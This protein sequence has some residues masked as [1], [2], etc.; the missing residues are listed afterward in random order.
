[1]CSTCSDTCA[2]D[3]KHLFPPEFSK[4]KFREELRVLKRS[5]A[6]QLGIGKSDKSLIVSSPEKR[7]TIDRPHCATL[8]PSLPGCRCRSVSLALIEHIL[9]EMKAL[10]I[11]WVTKDE[12]LPSGGGNSNQQFTLVRI[13][14]WKVNK[15]NFIMPNKNIST[16]AR[17]SARICNGT[18]ACHGTNEIFFIL[19]CR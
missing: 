13:P 12:T 19:Q 15:M 10:Y 16:K 8:F 18:N 1:M 5:D 2:S 11:R 7:N 6:I 9:R 3:E 17:K 14:P 4:N